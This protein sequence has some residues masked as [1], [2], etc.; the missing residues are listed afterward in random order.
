MAASKQ[1]LEAGA[2]PPSST[3]S[4][5]SM[6]VVEELLAR[7]YGDWELT[8]FWISSTMLTG[9]IQMY[10]WTFRGRMTFSVCYNEGFYDIQEVNALL[11]ETK[12]QLLAGLGI[13]QAV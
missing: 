9:D 10:L 2:V 7:E 12:R 13:Q 8:D 11:E 5:S 6:G 3:P 4:L 1:L